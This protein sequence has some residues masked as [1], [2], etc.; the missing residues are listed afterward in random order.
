MKN[1]IILVSS[2]LYMSLTICNFDF[3]VA[4]CNILNEKWYNQFS[5]DKSKK[6][7][8]FFRQQLFNV[9]FQASNLFEGKDIIALQ[10]WSREESLQIPKKENYQFILASDD[11]AIL[12]NALKF[13]L[14]HAEEKNYGPAL[15]SKNFQYALLKMKDGTERIIAIINTHFQGGPGKGGYNY[16]TLRTAQFEVIETFIAQKPPVFATIIC[17]D[18]NTDINSN[19]LDLSAWKNALPPKKTTARKPGE[20]I[21]GEAIDYI[22]YQGDLQLMSDSTYYPSSI[23]DLLSHG[24][25]NDQA[26]GY[27]SDHMLIAAYFR[28]TGNTSKEATNISDIQNMLSE[29]SK[30]L[31]SSYLMASVH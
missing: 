8:I 30:F 11:N 9:A 27:F 24:Y 22:L 16:S 19:I 25:Q 2:F 1:Y 13:E 12:Y 5:K 20:N 10:E 3:S 26:K 4:T 6:M 14:I 29:S 31:A 17:G 23:E 18:L 15:G 28:I 7:E 21:T